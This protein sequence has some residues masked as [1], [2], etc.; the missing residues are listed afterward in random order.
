[1]SWLLPALIALLLVF[2]LVRRADIY[3]AFVQGARDGLPLLA[4]VLPCIAAM[5]IAL[6]VLRASGA[7][8]AFIS[9]LSPTLAKIGMP[10]EL[11]PLFVLRPFSGSAAMSLLKDVFDTR[12]PDSY[13]GVAASI[14][15][16]S[17][18]TIFYTVALYFGSVGVH[19]TRLTI[20]V[21]LALSVLGAVL[22]LAFTT[23]LF[24][25]P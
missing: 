21:A 14:M 18:E 5:L 20:P 22:A 13:E 15:L 2:A 11:A 19:K 1:M 10:A 3:D 25:I 8:E 4:R 17:T 9:F 24:A 6:R 12:G 16:G 23:V 7:L